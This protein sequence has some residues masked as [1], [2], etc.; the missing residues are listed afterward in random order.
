MTNPLTKKKQ[1]PWRLFSWPRVGVVDVGSNAIR[2]TVAEITT[3]EI[4]EI[5]NKRFALRL[6]KDVFKNGSILSSRTQTN[7]IDVFSQI[8][9]IFMENGVDL[10]RAVATSAL[11]SARNR[12]Q[13]LDR[14]RKKTG[15]DLELIEASEEER[16]IGYSLP[17]YAQKGKTLLMD[18]GG[19]SLEVGAY[20]QAKL[21]G[22]STFPLGAVRLLSLKPEFSNNSVH[23]CK[24]IARICEKDRFFRDFVNKRHSSLKV[25]GSGGNIRAL[26]R[27]G[28]K[29]F[30]KKVGTLPR[31]SSQELSLII[32]KL[33]RMSSRQRQSK[34]K[35]PLD[36]ADVILPAAYVFYEILHYLDVK[37]IDVPSGVSLRRGILLDLQKQLF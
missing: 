20:D 15:I 14:I 2:V 32:Q 33:E 30:H 31:L 4:R 29:V 16:L 26:Y 12:K 13:I 21:Q 23:L 10:Y 5:E 35:L 6:G 19:G 24:H 17:L 3:S 25:V 7:L 22:M 37:S 27:V 1:R 9:N 18:L 36:R 11:R 8:K 28:R 34:F